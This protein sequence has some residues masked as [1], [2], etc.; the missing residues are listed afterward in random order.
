MPVTATVDFMTPDYDKGACAVYLHPDV[1]RECG[2]ET[3]DVVRLSTRRGLNAL[4]RVAGPNPRGAAGTVRLDRQIQ[5]TLRAAPREQLQVERTDP[6]PAQRIVL[7]P[8]AAVWGYQPLFLTHIKRVLSGARAPVSEGVLLYI[9]IP[10]T[11]AGITLEVHSV[12]DEAEGYIM[13]D[14]EV[15]IELDPAHDHGPE[16]RHVHP[17]GEH[18]R[19]IGGAVYE[20]VGG[21]EEQ[22]RAVR[23]FVELPLIFPQLYRRLGILPPRGVI[24]YGA[25]GT[26]KTLLARTVANEVN[27][28]FYYINGPEIV[29]SYSGQTEENLRRIFRS[30]SSAPPSI[31]FIDELDVVAPMRS[32]AGTVSDA[33]AVTQLLTLM[34]G[35]EQLEGQIVIGT[36]NRIE[37]VDPALRRPGRFAR[38]ST[39]PHPRPRPGSRS[40]A[41][42][43]GTCP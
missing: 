35:L 19:R 40:C 26:G 16:A 2:V 24:F 41:S 17:P 11:A 33:R 30:A 9:P 42:I 39:S 21:L 32:G 13:K 36:T 20:D 23:E 22:V 25:P 8:V 18:L 15:Y 43:P 1:M 12:Q 27:A 5:R 4:A 14:T 37:A 34:D 31:I 10:D 3:D 7:L 29:G 6:P 28:H 38:R